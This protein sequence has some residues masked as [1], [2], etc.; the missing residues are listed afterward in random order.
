LYTLASRYLEEAHD[1]G[2][3]PEIQPDALLMLAKSLQ[4]SRFFARSL[5]ILHELLPIANKR[6]PET[7]RLLANGYRRDPSHQ[8]AKALHHIDLYL[9]NPL[10]A[11]Q[12]NRGLLEK[13]HIEL[14][15]GDFEAAKKTFDM[16]IDEASIKSER[17]LLQGHLAIEEGDQL[18]AARPE[19]I[20]ATELALKKYEEA[21]SAFRE[22]AR[23]NY[24]TSNSAREAEL[25]IGF[26]YQRQDSQ[27]E[28]ALEQFSRVRRAHY[29]TNEGLA[30]GIREAKLLQEMGRDVEAIQQ[31]SQIVSDASSIPFYY[32]PFAPKDKLESELVE[33]VSDFIGQEKFEKALVLSSALAPI[34]PT[35]Q[36]KKLEVETH[37][38]WGEKLLKVPSTARMPEREATNRIARSHFRRA[39]KLAEEL[40]YLHFTT[41]EYLDDIWLSA[42]NYQRGHDFIHAAQQITRYLDEGAQDNRPLALVHLGDAYLSLGKLDKAIKAY[43]DCMTMFPKHPVVYRARINAS[44]GYLEQNE[45]AEAEKLLVTNLESEALTPESLEWRDSLFL[46]GDVLYHE[47]NRL[48]AESREIGVDR[49]YDVDRREGLRILETSKDAFLAAAIRMEEAVNRYPT[50][51]QAL[52]AMYQI[53]QSYRHAAKWAR[54][55]LP[56][57]TIETTKLNLSRQVQKQLESANFEYDKLLKKL[58]RRQDQDELTTIEKRLLRN[59]YFAK[60]DSYFDMGKYEEAITA[61]S[62]VTYRYL[63]SPI[64]LEAFVQMANCY[65][66]M[67]KPTEAVG[68]LIQAKIVLSRIPEEEDF[69]ATTRFGRLEWENFLNWISEV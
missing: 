10:P 29:S 33:A 9:A 47:A 20:E 38:T 14:A 30:A 11:E 49:E 24:A 61:Y 45:G 62:L 2:L 69:R 57:T 27:N 66:H 46:L 18:R 63:E 40:S 26:I 50:A 1:R 3:P 5:P 12:K 35:D 13:S 32:N 59:T 52:L 6:S 34:V 42:E 21:K 7:H 37:T 48:E 44:R 28:A 55:Q 39:A 8:Y 16:L 31:Y 53:A 41:R 25:M 67:N 60:A 17:L 43:L 65:H 4:G 54:K 36:I 51:P 22:V 58:I 19:D 23:Q 64:A 68:V 15:G 56:T